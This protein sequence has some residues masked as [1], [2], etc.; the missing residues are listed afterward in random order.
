MAE[1]TLPVD[2]FNPGQIFACVGILEGADVLLGAAKG[3]FDWAD[4][5]EVLFRVSANGDEPPVG[6]VLRFLEA[7]RVV[8]RAPHASSSLNGWIKKWGKTEVDPPDHPFSVP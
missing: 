6:R 7:A 1:S 8:A 5:E 4:G 3:A 2:L